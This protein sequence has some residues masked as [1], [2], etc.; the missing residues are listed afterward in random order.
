MVK[1]VSSTGLQVIA[2]R[3]PTSGLAAGDL[4]MCRIMTSNGFIVLPAEV[5]WTRDGRD[6]WSAGLSLR[7]DVAGA[8]ARVAWRQFC[9]GTHVAA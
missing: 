2:M 9:D 3:A 5:A 7:L 4:L 6:V 8:D 1:D